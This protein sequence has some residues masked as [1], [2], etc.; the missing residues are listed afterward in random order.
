MN[1]KRLYEKET[2]NTEPI[3]VIISAGADPSQE[4]EELAGQTIGLDKYH[5]VINLAR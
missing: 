5:Q 1:L 3:L 4:L 2:L